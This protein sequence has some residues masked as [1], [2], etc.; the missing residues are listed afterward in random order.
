M[1]SLKECHSQGGSKS[2][3]S[4]FLQQVSSTRMQNTRGLQRV[5]TVAA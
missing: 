2:L 5:D 1:H 4:T 3:G